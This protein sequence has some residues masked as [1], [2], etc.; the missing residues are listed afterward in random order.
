MSL[1]PSWDKY[2]LNMCDIISTRSLDENTKLG[3]V[4]VNDNHRIVSTGYNSLPAKVNDELW[5]MSRDLKLPIAK[6]MPTGELLILNDGDFPALRTEWDE[7]EF[8]VSKYD[9]VVHAEANAICSAAALGVSTQGCTLYCTYLPCHDCAK[10][11]I[12]AGIK[13]VVYIKE[14][15]RFEK[16]HAIAKEMFEQ[17][18]VICE[19]YGE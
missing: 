4:I 7:T 6:N 15:P 5:P 12:S 8:S 9:V 10:L 2:F 11:V 13:K 1:R 17:A 14:N 3:C 19:H 18:K 16:S